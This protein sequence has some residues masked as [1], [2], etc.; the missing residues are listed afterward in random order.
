MSITQNFITSR[1]RLKHFRLLIAIDEKKSLLK[2]ADFISI[3][4]PGA[5]KLLKEIESTFGHELFV[6]SKYGLVANDIGDCAVRYSRLIL[7]DL[8]HLRDELSDITKGYGGYLSVGMT[9]GSTPIMCDGILKF[10]KSRPSTKIQILEGTSI[11]LLKW[12]DEG[13]IELAIC[14]TNISSNPNNY[15]ADQ[16]DY[17]DII[18]AANSKHLKAQSSKITLSEISSDLWLMFGSN[19]PLRNFITRKFHQIGC[20]VPSNIIETTSILVIMQLLKGNTKCC[21]AIPKTV[22]QSIF[23]D[24]KITQLN[25]NMDSNYERTLLV[26]LANRPLSQQAKFLRDLIIENI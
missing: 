18:I 24:S 2:A 10:Q 25:V 20:P 23:N 4:Q 6:R 21:V 7:N 17:E 12:L 5:S 16:L 13:R 15:S 11:Q 1:L 22:A 19:T 26:R 14:R 8:D 9:M 3:T